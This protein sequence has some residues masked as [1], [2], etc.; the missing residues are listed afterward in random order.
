[1]FHPFQITGTQLVTVTANDRDEGT[2]ADITFDIST[3]DKAKFH[4]DPKSGLITTRVPLDREESGSYPLVITARD[5]GKPSLSSTAMVDITVLDE[6]DNSPKFPA[7]V[8]TASVLENT[9]VGAVILRLL[10]S[11]PDKDENGRVAYVIVSG[12]TDSAFK[13]DRDRGVVSVVKKLDRETVGSYSLVIRASD[14]A[15][16]PKSA[17]VRLDITVVDENDNAPVFVSQSVQFTVDE[18]CP[19]GTKAGQVKATDAD[20]GKN[21]EIVFSI[22]GG[23]DD[24]A[25][26]IDNN[27]RISVKGQIDREKVPKYVLRIRASDKGSPP[28]YTEKNF[29]VSVS[30]LNDNAPVFGSDEFRG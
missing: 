19:I 15:P 5:N 1:M 23:N 9:V 26:Q 8:Y 21:E 28:L 2:N 22:V 18:N 7:Q 27:G 20:I 17:T 13:I 12:N 30:D 6:N 29:N 25:F 11:D 3:G 4:V 14:S 16:N 24:D 10:A